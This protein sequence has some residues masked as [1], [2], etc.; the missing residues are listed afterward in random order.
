MFPQGHV[1]WNRLCDASLDKTAEPTGGLKM[2]AYLGF[3]AAAS[4]TLAPAAID[5][6]TLAEVVTT[7]GAIITPLDAGEVP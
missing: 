7:N 1:D 4:V 5:S 6:G 3:A 2:R